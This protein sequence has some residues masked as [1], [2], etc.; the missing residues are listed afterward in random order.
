[1][2]LAPHLVAPRAGA[3]IEI[4]IKLAAMKLNAVAPRAGAWIE[5]YICKRNK[6]ADNVAP[7]A[8]AWIEIQILPTTSINVASR[9]PCGCVD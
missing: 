6:T 2:T 8:G 3:W 1:M 4:E 5:I 9:T 7:R